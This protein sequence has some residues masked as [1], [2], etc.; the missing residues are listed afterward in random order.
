[1]QLTV[2]ISSRH[3]SQSVLA[4]FVPLKNGDLG[5]EV[6]ILEA[7]KG[8]AIGDVGSVECKVHGKQRVVVSKG[9]AAIYDHQ[10]IRTSAPIRDNE[11]WQTIWVTVEGY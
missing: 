10:G 7:V 11:A 9:V 5:A 8:G 1:M 2:E 4:D 6:A 3:A